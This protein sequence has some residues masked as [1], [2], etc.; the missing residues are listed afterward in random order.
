[1][2]SNKMLYLFL[3]TNSFLE[4]QPFES[5][6]WSEVCGK[7][8]F[9][10]VISPIVIREINKHKD[11]SK[12]KKRERARK[13]RKR[14]TEIAKETSPSRINVVFC[15]DPSKTAFEHPQFN[16]EIADD[17]LIFSALEFDAGKDEKIIVTNDTGIFLIAKEFGIKTVDIPEKYLAPSDPTDE[18][19]QIKE[20]K[21]RLKDIEDSLPHVIL[22]FDDG[23]TT[24]NLSKV[25]I[26]SMEGRL[27]SYRKELESKYP[28][29]HKKPQDLFSAFQISDSIYTED[30]YKKYNALI[31]PYLE[32]EPYNMVLRDQ[33]K[34]INESVVPLRFII[35]NIGAM[36]SGL[37]GIHL[38]FSDGAIIMKYD[39]S[40]CYVKLH[41]TTEPILKSAL[42]PDF[43]F[44]IYA[45]PSAFYGPPVKPDRIYVWDINNAIDTTETFFFECDPVI[46]NMPPEDFAINEYYVCL[47]LEQ[48]FEIEWEVIDSKLSDTIKGKLFVRIE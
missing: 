36:P 9:T 30:D 29:K 24:L 40:H 47:A 31:E 39:E 12:G 32:K 48:E 42:I 3:D 23:S 43:N 16:K 18:E 34:F 10:I 7:N 22:S 8:D 13:A 19:I 37:L 45:P 11:N 38:K 41:E 28:Y 21:K 35:K 17:W 4:F 46:Q 14:I 5:I 15:K 2:T 25:E 20:L 27:E 33:V 1:M 26:P 44:N 6:K